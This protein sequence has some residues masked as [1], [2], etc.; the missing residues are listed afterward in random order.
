M[1]YRQS[2]LNLN[3]HNMYES[4]HIVNQNSR[5]NSLGR[6]NL[7]K[8]NT[9][10]TNSMVSPADL[11]SMS[12]EGGGIPDSAQLYNQTDNSVNRLHVEPINVAVY[13]KMP[14]IVQSQVE[15]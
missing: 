9:I 14:S 3:L 12:I 1:H 11:D 15:T 10:T 5:T 8:H 13:S 7:L 4:N 2:P 6:G